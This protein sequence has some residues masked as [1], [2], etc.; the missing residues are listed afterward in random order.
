MAGPFLFGQGP[1]PGPAICT[2]SKCASAGALYAL[3]QGPQVRLASLGYTASAGAPKYR[4]LHVLLNSEQLPYS[5]GLVPGSKE[6]ARRAVLSE[7][8]SWAK[9]HPN[10]AI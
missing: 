10:D 3:L 5:L 2:F 8:D 6:E 4:L 9:K 1:R 7:Y